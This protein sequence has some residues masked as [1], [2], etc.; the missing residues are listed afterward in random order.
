MCLLTTRCE[1]GD[2]WGEWE[3]GGR[4]RAG[5]WAGW[6]AGHGGFRHADRQR[7]QLVPCLP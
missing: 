7:H 2:G 4:G 1:G 6:Q 5:E 3:G